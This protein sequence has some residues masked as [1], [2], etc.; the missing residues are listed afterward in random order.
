MANHNHQLLIV[1]LSGKRQLE[2]GTGYQWTYCEQNAYLAT[3]NP[4]GLSELATSQLGHSKSRT[5]LSFR[6]QGCCVLPQ[7][8]S[9]M[10]SGGYGVTD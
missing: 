8:P 10:F 2:G 7:L 4:E 1:T 3:E 6:S 9:T 5:L